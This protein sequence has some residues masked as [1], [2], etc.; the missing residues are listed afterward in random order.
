MTSSVDHVAEGNPS[1]LPW[2]PQR[3]MKK[4]KLACLS[5]GCGTSQSQRQRRAFLAFAFCIVFLQGWRYQWLSETWGSPSKGVRLCCCPDPWA[6]ISSTV[7]Q[8]L[9]KKASDIWYLKKINSLSLLL[10]CLCSCS[11]NGMN[12]LLLTKLKLTR[13]IDYIIRKLSQNCLVINF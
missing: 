13:K 7:Y 4:A 5:N 11:C 3:Y 6:L 9:P 12:S 1:H 2:R 10:R 8:N